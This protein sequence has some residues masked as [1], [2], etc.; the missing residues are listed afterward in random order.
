MVVAT[1]ASSQSPELQH[2]N[3]LQSLPSIPKSRLTTTTAP[4]LSVDREIGGAIPQSDAVNSETK[5]Q[6]LVGRSLA[7]LIAGGYIFRISKTENYILE[8]RIYVKL[9]LYEWL[10]QVV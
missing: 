6:P 9:T 1:T 3:S 7:H 5:A 8:S 2:H 10:V 4:P